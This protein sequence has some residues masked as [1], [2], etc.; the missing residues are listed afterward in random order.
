MLLE[1]MLLERKPR[2]ILYA[3]IPEPFRQPCH[4]LEYE[5]GC[6]EAM[7]VSKQLSLCKLLLAPVAVHCCIC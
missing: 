5:A 2:N 4:F 6:M 3:C 7:E 1:G